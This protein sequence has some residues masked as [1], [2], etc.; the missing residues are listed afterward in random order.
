ML[1]RSVCAA[2]AAVVAVAAAAPPATLNATVDGGVLTVEGA[3]PRTVGFA[4]S[5]LNAAVASLFAPL[6]PPPA[7]STPGAS[8]LSSRSGLLSYLVVKNGT[9]LADAPLS[10]VRQLILVL[11][12]VVVRPAPGFVRPWGGLI[13]LNGTDWVGV[14]SP[15]G[16]SR[17]RFECP[18]AANSPAAVWAVGSADV[19]VD[20]LTVDGCGRTEGGGIHLQGTPGSW[21]PTHSGGLVANHVVTNA[22]RGIWLETISR[23]AITANTLYGNA[24]HTLDFDAFSSNCAATGNRIFNNTQEAVF[25]EQGASGHVVAGNM[26][27]PGNGVGIA[28]YNNDLNVTCVNHVIVDNDIVDNLGPGVSV[29]STAPKAGTPD[30]AVFVV[31]NRIRGNGGARPQGVHTN[32]AQLAT[33]YAANDNVDGVSAYTQKL[34]SAMNVSFF[35]PLDRE[36]P[37]A[38]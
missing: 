16:P 28:V 19:V 20:G 33:V 5:A 8:L 6:Q 17:A 36:I 38:Y 11:D 30:V 22:M 37:L 29:G 26:L 2:L 27:G 24:K 4:F 23:V 18:D 15:G 7:A 34:G 3:Q 12:G 35:D 21:G 25:I 32:G 13:E 31:A 10:L 1:S 14:V 9:Y